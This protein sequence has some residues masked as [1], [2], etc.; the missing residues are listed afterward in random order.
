MI[1]FVDICNAFNIHAFI[2][3]EF[4]RRYGFEKGITKDSY[5]RGYVPAKEANKWVN[6][7]SE[8]LV[9]QEYSYKQEINKGQYTYRDRT[10]FKREKE[11]ESDIIRRYGADGD[12][13]TRT[14]IY[15]NGTS[16]KQRWNAGE[17]V[18][19]SD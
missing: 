15:C 14:N 9:F 4:V 5:G 6:K 1:R 10:R 2:V 16:R 12:S 17:C 7:L 8:Y 3:W 19:V 18:W 11:S 13:L